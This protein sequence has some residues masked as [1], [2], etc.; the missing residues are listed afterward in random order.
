MKE[1]LTNTLTIAIITSLLAP[2]ILQSI[3]RR[4]LKANVLSSLLDVEIARNA[5]NGQ[6]R[7][8]FLKST[9]ELKTS[10]FFA[11]LDTH[12]IDDYIMIASV[13]RYTTEATYK[14]SI[15]SK[16]DHPLYTREI[17]E[18]LEYMVYYVTSMV[19][20]PFRHKLFKNRRHERIVKYMKEVRRVDR[21]REDNDE[22]H[23]WWTIPHTHGDFFKKDRRAY[24]KKIKQKSKQK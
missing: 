17:A 11:K 7:E 19:R 15:E 12:L 9:A 24:N 20:S 16:S 14:I 1:L 10:A 8:Q 6:T 21:K 5:E 18:L 22:F 23:M 4:K 13:F 2:Y 3:E